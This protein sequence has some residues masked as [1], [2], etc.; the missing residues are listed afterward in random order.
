MSS[1]QEEEQDPIPST[2]P[3]FEATLE[4]LEYC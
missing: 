2:L 4:L 1:L 3:A